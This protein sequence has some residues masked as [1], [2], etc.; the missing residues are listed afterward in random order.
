MK[1]SKSDRLGINLL[2]VNAFIYITFALYTPFLSSY[3]SK[4]GLNA[5]QIGILLTIGPLVAIVIQPLWAILSDKTGRRK[6]ILIL[7][8]LGSGLSIFSYYL[9]N[10]FLTFFIA[11]SLLAVFSNSIVPLNDAITLRFTNRYQLDFSRI[12]MGGTIGYAIFVIIAGVIVRQNPPVQFVM[13]FV[14]YMVTLF[15][16][17]MLPE[18][19]K[20]AESKA[21]KSTSPEVPKAK[22]VGLLR[23]FESKQIYFMLAFAFISQAGLS[24]NGSFIGVYM[25]NLGLSETMIGIINSICA[26]SEIPILFII[27]KLLHKIST[28]KIIV[29][30]CLLLGIRLLLISSS[31]LGLMMAAQ[32]MN[33]LTYMT[34]YFS[35]AVYIS[36]NVKQENQSKGQSVL[37]IV[38]AGIG[39]IVGNIA[40][41][42][43]VDSFGLDTAY[44]YMAA[45]II[46]VTIL[47]AVLQFIYIRNSRPAHMVN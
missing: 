5:L 25:I 12:R 31:S 30:S 9:G 1:I 17:R 3:Y 35:C 36:K 45:M 20:A 32:A 41:G 19:E 37:T 44:R 38:Q 39:S 34:I 47:L 24:F 21:E 13:G 23:I 15:V 22:K 46:A 4:A 2:L 27:N 28:P 8:I 16:V 7:V 42:I 6:D 10:T 40:G 11:A 33:G 26:F 29:F 14:G 43:F 18:D